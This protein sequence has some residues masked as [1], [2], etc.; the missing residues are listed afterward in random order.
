MEVTKH[1]WLYKINLQ[2]NMRK[3]DIQPRWRRCSMEMSTRSWEELW[4]WSPSLA[5]PAPLSCGTNDSHQG[6]D[7]KCGIA[8]RFSALCARGIS[9]HFWNLHLIRFHGEESEVHIQGPKW[10]ITSDVTGKSSPCRNH[11]TGPAS[12]DPRADGKIR[13]PF[14]FQ[15]IFHLLNYVHFKK[16]VWDC[17][18]T[19]LTLT[20]PQRALSVPLQGFWGAIK[21]K[22]VLKIRVHLIR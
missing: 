1:P 4:T 8:T 7:D 17:K 16:Q 13:Y 15:I 11:I 6:G 3:R 2:T 9:K 14:F 20:A 10:P 18:Q 19:S 22:S 5:F 12:C 21:P